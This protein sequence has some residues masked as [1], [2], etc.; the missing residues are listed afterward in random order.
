MATT[1]I[2]M[3]IVAVTNGKE[4]GKNSV[5]HT[6]KTNINSKAGVGK[7]SALLFKIVKITPNYL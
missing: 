4:N 1:D 6:Q 3:N 2:N 5:K 7:T